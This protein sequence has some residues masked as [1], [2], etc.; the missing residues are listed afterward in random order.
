M[1]MIAQGLF[2]KLEW[3]NKIEIDDFD[4]YCDNNY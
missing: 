3:I 2:S 1:C 4:K